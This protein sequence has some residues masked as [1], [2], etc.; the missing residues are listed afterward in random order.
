[1]KKPWAGRFREATAMSVERFTESISFDWRLW[2]YD[3]MG[4]IAHA[5]MLARRKIISSKEAADIIRGLEEIH[6]EIIE[7]RFRFDPALEDI[8]MNIENALIK[9]TGNA[10]GK[11]HTARSRNDQVALD[12]RLFIRD[13]TKGI[14]GLVKKLQRILLNT[15]RKHT[16]TVMP[17]YTHLQRAQPVVLGHHILAYVEMLQRDRERFD[18]SLKR[19]DVLPLGACALAGTTLPIDRKFLA[20]QLG[21]RKI[22]ENSMDAV[23]D[24]DFA[25]EFL[26]VSAIIMMHL[27][28]MAEE[29]VLWSSEEFSFIEI[30]DSFTTGSSIMPQKKNPDVAELL[31]GKTGRTYGNLVALLTVMKGLPLTYNRDMQED[32]IPIFDTADTLKVSLEVLIDMYPNININKQRMK[33]TSA[34]GYSTATEIADYLVLKGLPFREAHEVVGKIVGYCIDNGIKLEEL[35]TEKFRK[36]SPL[37]GNDVSSVT[38][39]ESSISRKKSLGGTAP[40]EVARQIQRLRKVIR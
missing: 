17:G 14:T 20:K 24:R 31:R 28:R 37:F 35:P 8:H 33:M 39:I 21:F 26:A 13:E 12:L 19:I 16:K 3:I 1:M 10:G 22:S 40:D 4:S 11:L 15:A 25:I 5:K 9:K 6:S 29:L 32:K 36:F 7:D 27:S 2:K 38:S 18:D 30:S 23:S 34:D